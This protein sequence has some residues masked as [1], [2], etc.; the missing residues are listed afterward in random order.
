MSPQAAEQLLSDVETKL[1]E[2]QKELAEVTAELT[3]GRMDLMTKVGHYLA[4][5]AC[6]KKNTKSAGVAL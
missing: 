1:G 3:Q 5:H 4:L 2:K 6:T